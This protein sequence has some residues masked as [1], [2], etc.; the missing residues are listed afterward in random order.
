MQEI[1]AGLNLKRD[2]AT[3]TSGGSEYREF[4]EETGLNY[5]VFPFLGHRM[6]IQSTYRS[7]AAR[8]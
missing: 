4:I 8:A 7:A 5:P 1:A 3:R 6:L 2:V